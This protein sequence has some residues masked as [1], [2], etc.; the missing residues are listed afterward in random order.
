MSAA[1][2]AMR[3]FYLAPAL[4]A[5]FVTAA[6]AQAPAGNH[7]RPP[8]GSS[9]TVDAL[10]ELPSSA[11]IFAL[12]DTAIP[13]VVADRLDTGGLSAGDPARV[14]A[15]GS[16]WTQ[17][18]FRV[19]DVDITDPNGNGTPLLS[20]GVVE[21]ER[22]D[23]STGI[24]PVD[25]PA[26]G[27]SVS[28]VPR[29]PF[30]AWRGSFDV[31]GSLPFLNAG[32]STATPPSIAR[33]NT[34]AHGNLVAGGPAVPDR[35][36]A[37]ISATWTRS[38]HFERSSTD[39]LDANHAAAFV[40]L[41]ATPDPSNQLGLIGWGQRTRDPLETH[42]A[43][44]QPT[45]A[46]RDAALHAQI[47]WQRVTAAGAG[48]RAFGGLTLRN[49]A[50]DLQPTSV[51]M[52]ERLRDGPV[53]AL[54]D[55]GDGVDRVWDV[56]ARLHGAV[57]S[58]DY[59]RHTLVAGA[60]ASGSL[61]SMQPAF[62]GRVAELVNGLPARIWE[63]THPALE[64]R[65]HETSFTAYAADT[66]AVT[67]R[68]TLNAGARFEAVR[69]FASDTA[70]APAVSWTNLY[71]RGGLHVGLTDFW[72]IGAF[73][74]YG[75]YGHRLPL[76]DL[77]YGDPTAS[78]GAVYRWTGGDP[79]RA[80]SRGPLVQRVGPGTGGNPAF[81]G[82]DPA[83]ERPYMDEVIFGFESR[84]HPSAFARMAAIARREQPLIGV[85]DVGVP[86]SA[87]TTIGVPDPGVDLASP[88]D[89]QI[90]LFYNRSPA[91]FGADRYL[92][93]NPPDHVATF[94]GVDITGEVHAKQLFVIAGATAGR[95]EG[96]SANRGFGPLENDAGVLGEVFIDP[97]ARAHAQGRLFTERGYT[98]KTALAYQIDEGFTAALIG[99]YEDGQHFARMVVMQNLNQGTEAVRAFR[100]GRT[101]F[102]FSMTVD[103]RVQ[104]SI[105]LGDR[106]V[107]LVVDAYNLFNQ[108][109]EAEEF[110]VTGAGAR[111][112]S[113]VQPPRVLHVG[114]RI[115]F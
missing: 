11:T 32:G 18:L 67:S 24:M 103:A 55:P 87:Y 109:L 36:G 106:Q 101:R 63:F 69:A 40:H 50:T 28:L 19:G 107:T 25:G 3:K 90:L 47:A 112:T 30:D 20:P 38:S 110:Q 111:L 23:V 83:L 62:A 65:W 17:T 78:T 44:G 91:S 1:L 54:L 16:T 113:A 42:A 14:G 97:N 94:V 39:V 73:A 21:W 41:T 35:L 26:P 27:L 89:D 86:E 10:G 43:L 105:A 22:V 49:R 72:R 77:A 51:V 108:S 74:Q 53:P 13:D 75:R 84:P 29:R 82:I 56:G 104:K 59:G 64:S 5:T 99:R 80:S 70:D 60:D 96:L 37:F 92:L 15:H 8:L 102:T 58:A 85:V 81:S 115:P 98:L 34:W 45:S 52:V 2:S 71:P 46:E 9:I 95:S 79:S 4:L 48:V 114:L 31:F 88:A 66:V 6:A 57:D 76:R 61:T 33:L 12:L 68:L 100:N 7:E 93:T